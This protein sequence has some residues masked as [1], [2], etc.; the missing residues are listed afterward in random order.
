[1]SL[2]KAGKSRCT[3]QKG[4]TAVQTAEE[5]AYWGPVGPHTLGLDSDVAWGPMQ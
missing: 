3:E 5:A 2:R 4:N 1:M